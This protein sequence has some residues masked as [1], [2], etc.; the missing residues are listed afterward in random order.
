MVTKRAILRWSSTVFD[1]LGLISPVTISAKL[2][3]QQ[4]WQEHIS[5]DTALNDDLLA[6]WKVIS[7]TITDS[8]T[9]SFPRMYTA[10]LLAPQST[11]T[12][13][14]VFADASLKAYWAVAYIQQD[15]GSPSFVMSK[16]RAA[17][18]KHLTLPKLE[19]KAAVLAAKLISFIKTSLSLDCT[20]QL[21]SDSQIVL[22]W[23]AS[24]KPLQAFVTRR[25]EEIRRIYLPAGSIVPQK[26]TQPTS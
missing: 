14:H 19:L 23:I 4:L 22:Y 3:L 21:W 6:R 17:P 9:L 18:L 7:D 10:S 1:P 2:F 24:H 11:H 13:L 25:V 5:W 16:S 15:Q 20:V 12:Y 8:T 26:S